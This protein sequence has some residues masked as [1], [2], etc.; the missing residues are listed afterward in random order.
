MLTLLIV[1]YRLRRECN[2]NQ[3]KQSEGLLILL[4][5]FISSASNT[6][7]VEEKIGATSI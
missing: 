1:N 7:L 5:L 2:Q 4:I 6:L 3:N